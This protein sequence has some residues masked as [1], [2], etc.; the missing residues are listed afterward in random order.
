MNPNQYHLD[1][2][3]LS[4]IMGLYHFWRY[5]TSPRLTLEHNH[6]PKH[7]AYRL[8]VSMANPYDDVFKSAF[9]PTSLSH[10]LSIYPC[11]HFQWPMV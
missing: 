2:P 11:L 10:R 4:D 6:E 5:P 1:I 8:S 3:T 9:V 7:D